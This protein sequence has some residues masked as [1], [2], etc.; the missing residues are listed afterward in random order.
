MKRLI[1]LLLPVALA[2]GCGAYVPVPQEDSAVDVGYEKASKRGLTHAV[3]KL[4][5]NEHEVV[6]YNNI[7]DYLQGRVAGV[8]VTPDKRILI[9]GINSINSST[10][11]LIL[12]DGTEMSDISAL[13]PNDI[14]SV[15]VL[16]DASSS[17]YGVRGGNGVILITTK[18]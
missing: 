10:D 3:S 12:V 1:H 15:S 17:I 16:K 6:T 11:P 4:K 7:F 14:E 18:H 2:T 9:R 8:Q 5:M 13:N